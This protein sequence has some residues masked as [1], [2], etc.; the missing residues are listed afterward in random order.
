MIDIIK[1]IIWLTQYTSS[2][3]LVYW[4]ITYGTYQ[5][6]YQP[7]LLHVYSHITNILLTSFAW[8]IPYVMVLVPPSFYG[9]HASHLGHQVREKT[10]SIT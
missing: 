3:L 10:W 6:C 9:L 2:D 4:S 5:K 1:F 8:S 7:A